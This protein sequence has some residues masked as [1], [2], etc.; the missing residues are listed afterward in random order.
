MAKKEKKEIVTIKW[1]RL[2]CLAI[3]VIFF[4]I[5]YWGN[6]I[7]NAPENNVF[8]YTI[9]Y[10]FQGD[11]AELMLATIKA[12]FDNGT[13][14]SIISFFMIMIIEIIMFLVS[15]KMIT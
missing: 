8:G 11:D 4:A 15:L 6:Q 12:V 9:Q 1:M 2:A 13:T 10:F 7:I 5:A 3:S 14:T